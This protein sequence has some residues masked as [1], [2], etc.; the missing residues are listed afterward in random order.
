[1]CD[2]EFDHEE[3][4][5]ET[6]QTEPEKIVVSVRARQEEQTTVF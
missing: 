5:A 3:L 1:V 6:T 4:P 2:Y